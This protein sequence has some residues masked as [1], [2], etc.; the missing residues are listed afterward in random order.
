M[1]GPPGPPVLFS[2]VVPEHNRGQER[3]LILVPLLTL[4]QI[5]KNALSLPIPHVV[6]QLKVHFYQ[7]NVNLIVLVFQ[8]RVIRIA[9]MQR[10]A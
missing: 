2:T 9:M 5:Q 4:L 7:L 1:L 3:V 10:L 6:R 8:H